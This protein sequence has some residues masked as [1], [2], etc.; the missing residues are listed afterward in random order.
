MAMFMKFIEIQSHSL[1]YNKALLKDTGIQTIETMSK[2]DKIY[3]FSQ[4]EPE[5]IFLMYM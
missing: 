2:N 5:S 3:K 4:Q 1:Q